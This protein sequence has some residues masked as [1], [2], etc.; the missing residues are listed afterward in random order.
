MQILLTGTQPTFGKF[1]YGA[2]PQEGALL[3]LDML[4]PRQAGG[5][6]G[7]P[8]E[9]WP[10]VF[11]HS[12]VLWAIWKMIAEANNN[13]KNLKHHLTVDIVNIETQAIISRILQETGQQ[14]EPYPGV[15]F[16][17]DTVYGQALLGRF[18]CVPTTIYG[19]VR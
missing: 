18:I 4:G 16:Q 3:A 14:L 15:S 11:R 10:E 6:W 8:R 2:N 13:L 17:T 12:D 7:I 9:E 5:R 1:V 19:G